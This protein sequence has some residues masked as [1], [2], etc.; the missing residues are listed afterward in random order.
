MTRSL[1]ALGLTALAVF[2]MSALAA[3]AASANPLFHSEIED[4]TLTGAQ[5]AANVLSIDKGEM[6]CE[7]VKFTGTMEAATTSTM[8]LTPKY[9]KCK[10][11]E[12]NAVVTPNGCG[13]LFHL[14][15][16]SETFEASM[17]I[18]CPVGQQLEIDME[19]CTITIPPQTGLKKVTFTNEGATTTRSVIAD[20]S[21][22]GFHYV[23]HGFLCASET[24]TTNN[25]GYAGQI[26][27]TGENAAQM[28][29]GIWV[30]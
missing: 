3:S 16:N 10:L 29:K 18:E 17:D 13:Y 19:F 23:E 15:P 22:T 28:H 5:T 25:G 7:T 2:A 20:L 9:E 27:V 4:T 1:K 24:V 6:K 21:I 12:Q 30:A 26:T 8:T 11:A 14:A